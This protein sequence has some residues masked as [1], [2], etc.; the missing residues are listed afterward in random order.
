MIAEKDMLSLNTVNNKQLDVNK[1]LNGVE[2][3]IHVHSFGGDAPFLFLIMK[4]FEKS[5]FYDRSTDW[6]YISPS[7]RIWEAQEVMTRKEFLKKVPSLL[8]NNWGFVK[9][10]KKTISSIV[11][12]PDYENSRKIFYL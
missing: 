6:V 7:V 3:H 2:S 1:C 8:K 11:P 5:I 4:N 10:N 12:W 9:V